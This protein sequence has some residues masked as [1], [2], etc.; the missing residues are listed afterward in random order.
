[1]VRPP[2]KRPVFTGSEGPFGTPVP[3]ALAASSAASREPRTSKRNPPAR[4]NCKFNL[5]FRTGF[6]SQWMNQKAVRLLGISHPRSAIEKHC[7]ATLKKHTGELLHFHRSPSEPHCPSGF[8]KRFPIRLSA[9]RGTRDIA[10]PGTGA[11]VHGRY[12]NG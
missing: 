9:E 4:R 12:E 7:A 3:H 8:G 1:M 10:S 6:I 5:V 2:G 11:Q